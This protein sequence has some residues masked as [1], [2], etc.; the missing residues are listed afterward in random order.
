MVDIIAH[1]SLDEAGKTIGAIPGDNTQKEVTL[2]RI[3][4]SRGII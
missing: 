2:D 1:A 4:K 3:I